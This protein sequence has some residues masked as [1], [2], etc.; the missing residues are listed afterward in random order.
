VLD[1]GH[2]TMLLQHSVAGDIDADSYAVLS[3][4]GFPPWL[5]AP[6]IPVLRR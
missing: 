3:T 2:G 4:A 1:V 6:P 5:A